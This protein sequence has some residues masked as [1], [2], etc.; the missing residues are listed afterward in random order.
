MKKKLLLLSLLMLSTNVYAMPIYSDYTFVGYSDTITET[1]DLYKYEQVK[2]NK[3]YK[4]GETN[5]VYAPYE[6]KLDDS[7]YIDN[8]STQVGAYFRR[9]RDDYGEY[10]HME[11]F[12]EDTNYRVQTIK[13]S[14]VALRKNLLNEIEIFYKGN[15]LD[16]EINDDYQF[17]HDGEYDIGFNVAPDGF[18][19]NMDKPYN[20]QDLTII[21]HYS[22]DLYNSISFYIN[23]VNADGGKEIAHYMGLDNLP[24]L[25]KQ[26]KV[27]F[28]PKDDFIRIL[29]DN[30]MIH[31][32]F[33]N[34]VDLNTCYVYKSLLY[35]H[36]NIGKVYYIE[37]EENMIDGYTYDENESVTKYKVYKREII[38]E[39]DETEI[40]NE[41]QS[42]QE[43]SIL[44]KEPKRE[45]SNENVTIQE[46]PIINETT[47]IEETSTSTIEPLVNAKT[48]TITKID[49][50]SN[51]IDN[52]D[53]PELYYDYHVEPIKRESP[54]KLA[55]LDNE[56][57]NEVRVINKEDKKITPIHIVFIILEII[58]VIVTIYKFFKEKS[59]QLT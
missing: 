48:S 13:F 18:T 43:E 7:P 52:Y 11:F 10:E 50:V 31:P 55:M 46:E 1:N 51:T 30:N 14:Q 41:K 33:Y 6:V 20:I 58:L 16:Y 57:K 49:N 12:R 27:S 21:F 17:L 28:I 25:Y 35:K 39:K 26:T 32:D 34:Q 53:E 29:S 4:M 38:G 42:I 2:L 36:Y 15:K 40:L 19:I 59:K 23:F 24:G 54:N 3:F 5:I 8:T 56:E 9:N 44:D 22:I 45:I 47:N 37:S